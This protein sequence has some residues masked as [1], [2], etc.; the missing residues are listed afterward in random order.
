MKGSFGQGKK[1]HA[2][3]ALQCAAFVVHSYVS[4][5]AAVGTRCAW[6]SRLAWSPLLMNDV[7]HYDWL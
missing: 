6:T 7:M 1:S 5:T 3:N 4:V 2:H